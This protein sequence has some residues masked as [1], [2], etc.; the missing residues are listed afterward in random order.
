MGFCEIFAIFFLSFRV[1]LIFLP[2]FFPVILHR[3]LVLSYYV[4]IDALLSTLTAF[5]FIVVCLNFYVKSLL[6]NDFC[7]SVV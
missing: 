7:E 5:S 6:E 3:L 2:D 1:I 4:M